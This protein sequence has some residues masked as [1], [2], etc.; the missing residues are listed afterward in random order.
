MSSSFDGAFIA[1]ELSISSQ[2]DIGGT[3]LQ[4]TLRVG[5]AGLFL[6][7][8]TE[9]GSS[10]PATVGERDLHVVHARLEF[11]L[12]TSSK[13]ANSLVH[14]FSPYI[15]VEGRSLVGGE[16]TDIN[17]LGQNINFNSGSEEDVSSAFAGARYSVLKSK[18]FGVVASLEA[19]IDTK[20]SSVLSGNIGVN[21]RF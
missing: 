10:A 17:L 4:P 1:P 2:Y 13:G 3:V 21:W 19:G 8:F 15:G 11:A 6:D 14:H 12:L 5:Y 9:T 16:T 18:V 20:Q 7:G